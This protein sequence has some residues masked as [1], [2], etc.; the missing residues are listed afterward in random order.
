MKQIIYFLIWIYKKAFHDLIR[1]DGIEHAGYISFLL[2]LSIFPFFI[3]CSV[4]INIILSNFISFIDN[5]IIIIIK[6]FLLKNQSSIF[7]LGLKQRIDEIINTPPQTF[8]GLAL[9]SI[10]WTASSILEAFR[11][12]L[13]RAYRVRKP[14]HYIFR[15]ALSIMQFIFIVALVVLFILIT[16]LLPIISKF[17]VYPTNFL[18]KFNYLMDSLSPLAFLI[19]T[20]LVFLFLSYLYFI[21]PNKKQKFFNT[22]IGTF[23]TM[24]GWWIM[25]KIFQYYIVVFPQINL[26]YGSIANI[27]IA[28]LYFYICSILFI[29]GAEL[30]YW[31]SIKILKNKI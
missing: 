7:T 14:P 15:R 29:Y 5:N 30:N 28:L 27:I 26:I 25:T 9:V 8:V 3:F 2:M 19:H 12:I 4:F 18:I 11:T 31:F 24:I 20:T 10:V 17:L 23:H 13:N 1:H 22:F 6:N 21:L 16:K